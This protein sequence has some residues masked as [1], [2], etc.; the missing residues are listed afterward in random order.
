MDYYIPSVYSK[1]LYLKKFNLIYTVG[2]FKIF[3]LDSLWQYNLSLQGAKN[4]AK[5]LI[6]FT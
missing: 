4:I 1:L 3:L 6:K 2:F 5:L